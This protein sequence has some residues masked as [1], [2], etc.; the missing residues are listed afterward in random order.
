MRARILT[1]FIAIG[2][3]A[4]LM[5]ADKL[6]EGMAKTGP[7]GD[8]SA[9]AKSAPIKPAAE[10]KPLA[11]IASAKPA[12]S[13]M[14]A[15]VAKSNIPPKADVQD[16]VFRTDRGLY[17]LRLLITVNGKPATN[18]WRTFMDKA[19]DYADR[20][21]DGFLSPAEVAVMPP[22]FAYSQG[23]NY[24]FN[25][26]AYGRTNFA[27][28]DTNKDGK[29]SR[30]E[31]V[32]W[33]RRNGQGTI[34][35]VMQPPDGTADAL[36]NAFFKA[37][38]SSKD[39][40][41]L[42]D[43][44]SAWDKLAKL[45]EDEDEIVTSQELLQRQP[46]PYGVEA[47]EVEFEAV[48]GVN[49]ARTMRRAPTS[50][51]SLV[52]LTDGEPA[53]AQA[54]KIQQ[55]FDAQKQSVLPLTAARTSEKMPKFA[56]DALRDV[57][58]ALLAAWVTGPPDLELSVQ[59]GGM[60]EGVERVFSR[61]AATGVRVNTRG[62]TLESAAKVG[63]DGLLRVT[64]PGD[65]VEFSRATGNS[66]TNFAANIQYYMQQ[67]KSEAGDKKY[68]DKQQLQQSPQIQF[69]VGIFDIADRNGD[70]KLYVDE[71]Q[72]FIDLLQMGSTSQVTVT[73]VD[74]GRGL[75]DLIDV[76][77]DFRLSRRELIDAAKNF[78]ALDVTGTGAIKKSDLP[79]QT[80][81][82]IG[83]GLNNGQYAV[84]VF[85]TGFGGMGVSPAPTRGPAWFRKMDRNRDGDVSLR[86]F[87]GTPEEF[88]QIDTDGDGLI[89]LQEAEAFEKARKK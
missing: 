18:A 73:A 69:F 67:F 14:D 49:Y 5:A 2:F 78:A 17:K 47:Q 27:D 71:F 79:K 86:E 72:K 19:F 50:Q 63:G 35:V 4:T 8:K 87:L 70:G 60:A 16:L 45:D 81:V 1:A 20:N 40:L 52:S 48:D 54:A 80:R 10:A 25:G 26:Q 64:V 15:A 84:P 56:R 61:G 7:G 23:F 53:N 66:A 21:N 44:K 68:V 77:H 24:I 30:E 58:K 6:P 88:K 57:E 38:G 37:V 12:T 83:Q 36:T 65:I 51:S 42:A 76:N 62:A 41:T 11:E 29:V 32:A 13:L 89:S 43:M 55:F 59:L 39:K 28:L 85:T 74:R 46:N 33:M 82:S 34:N 75:F 22:A 31:F 3:A 9:E